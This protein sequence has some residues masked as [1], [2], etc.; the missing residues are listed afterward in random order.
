MSSSITTIQARKQQLRRELRRRRRALTPRQQQQAA[1][2][3][4]RRVVTSNLFR[5]SRRLAFTLARD[6]EISSERLLH[7]AVRRGKRCYLPVMRQSSNTHLSF[8]EWRRGARLRKGRFGILEPHLGRLGAPYAL[9]VVFMPL[10]GFDARCNRLGMGRAYYDNTFAFLRRT[11]RA[12]PA[13]VGLAHDCQRVDQLALAPWDV[14]LCA[15]A[16]DRAWY[17]PAATDAPE[18]LP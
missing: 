14:P 5:F 16:T 12:R 2:A 13:L 1:L 17:H 15:I 9:D 6:G 8:R 11:Q 3:L 18:K 7:E 4:Y 10:V